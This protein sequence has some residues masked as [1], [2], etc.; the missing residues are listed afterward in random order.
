ML[1]LAV[2]AI[3][4]I[5][6]L[7]ALMIVTE[8]LDWPVSPVWWV[9]ALLIWNAGLKLLWP[10]H[11]SLSQMSWRFL[12]AVAGIF[13][14]VALILGDWSILSYWTIPGVIGLGLVYC[15]VHMMWA[16]RFEDDGSEQGR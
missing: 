6:I 15:V 12:L 13:S 2:Q 10:G 7:V 11:L 3:G 9:I 5:A 16:P 14:L 1:G 8:V 4:T